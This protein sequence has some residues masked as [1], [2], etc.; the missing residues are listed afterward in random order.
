MFPLSS[1]TK[2][3]VPFVSLEVNGVTCKFLGDSGASV[4]IVSNDLSKMLDS[5]LKPCDTKVY[6]FNSSKPLSMLGKFK[7]LVESNCCSVDSEFLV[8]DG[9]TSLLGYAAAV[10]RRVLQ[11]YPSLFSGLGKMKNV[12]VK[13]HINENVKPMHQ[14]QRHIPFHQLKNL[15]ACVESLLQQDIIEPANGPTLWVSPMVSVPK[16]RQAQFSFFGFAILDT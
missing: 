1:P 3:S 8:V 13:L 10:E 5:V 12:E 14:S 6:A 9:K 4:N 11:N 2:I 7:A 15:E 16:P